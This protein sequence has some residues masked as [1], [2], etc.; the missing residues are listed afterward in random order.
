MTDDPLLEVEDL[1][2]EF[3]GLVAV[4]GVSFEF[5][6]GTITGLIGPNGAG[7]TTTFNLISGFYR[8]DG[9]TIRFKGRDV[10]DVM[11]PLPIEDRIWTAASASTLGLLGLGVARVLY[12]TSPG[13]LGAGAA[14]GAGVGVGVYYGQSAV[15]KRREDFW[16]A[17]PYQ[18]ARAGMVRTFQITRELRELTVLEN[19]LL[20]PQDQDGEQLHNAILRRDKIARDESANRERAREILTLLDLDHLQD[21]EAGNLSGGQRKLLELG[22]VLMLDPD[23]VLLDEPVAGVNPAL[24]ERIMETIKSMRDEGLGFCVVEHEMDVIMELSDTIVVM[25]EGKKLAEGTPEEVQEDEA[26]L[27]AYLGG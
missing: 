17:R 3:G 12:G 23:L 9:G 5:E 6:R 10:K 18:M 16:P 13:V 26:V 4:D 22:R 21:E 7:K 19:L 20:A 11:Q 24:E 27:E 14:V 25:S 2:K 8:P 15:N 1:R